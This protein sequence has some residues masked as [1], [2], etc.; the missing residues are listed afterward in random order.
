MFSSNIT[1]KVL[2]ILIVVCVSTQI[3]KQAWLIL[4]IYINRLTESV[5]KVR[6]S[7]PLYLRDICHPADK[8]HPVTFL[9]CTGGGAGVRNT[10]VNFIHWVYSCILDDSLTDM[11]N[12]SLVLVEVGTLPTMVLWIWATIIVI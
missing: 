5:Y 12:F 2:I 9:L 11:H 1:V 3:C 8:C 10:T 6:S 4:W 7:D